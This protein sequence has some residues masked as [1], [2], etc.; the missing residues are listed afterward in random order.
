[1]KRKIILSLLI[2]NLFACQF[3][4]KN[5]K[6]TTIVSQPKIESEI[7]TSQASK[8]DTPIAHNQFESRNLEIPKEVRKKIPVALLLPLSGKNKELGIHLF[9]AAALSLFEND[10]GHRIELVLIDS[11]DSPED[12]KK[13][14]QNIID[15]KIKIVIGP[16]FSNSVEAIKDSAKTNG[17]TVI[18]LSNNHQFIG[19]TNSRGGVFLS[20]MML[21]SQID[22]VV[23]YSMRQGQKTF[24][25]ISPNNQYGITVADILKRTATNRDANFTI[26]EVYDPN[27]EKGLERSI[28]RIVNSF[29]IPSHLA[30]GGGNKIKKDSLIKESD[31]S[32]VQA[33]LIPESGK[34]LAKIARLIKEANKSEREIK[35]L[36]TNQWDDLSTLSNDDLVGSYFPAPKD[37]KFRN[38]E[39]KYYQFYNKFPPRISS[40]TYDLVNLIAH[41]ADAK[42][43]E[44]LEFHDFVSGNLI[45]NGFDGIDGLFRFLP[46]GYVQRNLA[47]L[48]VGNGVFNVR[49]EP[50]R[51]FLKY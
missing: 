51:I 22:K 18:S 16:I 24:A 35:L 4:D 23:N 46:N 50:A 40:I 34:T 25:A 33:I 7:N 47:V 44:N 5:M 37:E 30:E 13:A 19:N 10:L 3:L 49:E 1:M 41:L 2:L 21:E 26:S 14:F 20:G 9:N 29:S 43:G 12:T 32:Y 48:E 42:K 38:F 8:N 36:G 11:K 6:A 31:R 17:I 28:E 15:R 45:D 27:T 39:K